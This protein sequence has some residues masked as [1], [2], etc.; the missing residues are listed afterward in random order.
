MV[1]VVCGRIHPTTEVMGFL[2]A[3]CNVD[4][5]TG[6]G[7]GTGVSNPDPSDRLG[8]RT[9]LRGS[10]GSHQQTRAPVREDRQ[11]VFLNPRATRRRGDA[12]TGE[13]L[14]TGA[15]VRRA[16]RPR[17]RVR[18]RVRRRRRMAPAH[19]ARI[20]STAADRYGTPR[21]SRD[22]RTL[23]TGRT[24]SWALTPS[25]ESSRSRS[26]RPAQADCSGLDPE[27]VQGSFESSTRSAPRARWRSSIVACTLSYPR[28]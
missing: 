28:S 21:S 23:P 18:H 5:G 16:R 25:D 9:R 11:S 10:D 15:A 17:V 19:Q 1:R 13:Q 12:G 2:P 22:G 24:C 7:P 14:R 3:F 20:G 26:P 4:P 8:S 27:T 6:T